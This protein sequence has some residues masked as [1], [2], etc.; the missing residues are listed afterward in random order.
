MCMLSLVVKS[1][2]PL[3]LRFRLLIVVA[4]LVGAQTLGHMG[5]SRRSSQAPECGLSSYG[6]QTWLVRCMWH[7]PRPGIKLVSLALQGGFLTTEPPG[8][9]VSQRF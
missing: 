8:K 9:P 2:A 6:T 5:F 7:L 3:Y 4:S 1:G